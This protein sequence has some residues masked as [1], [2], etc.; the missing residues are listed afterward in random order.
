MTAQQIVDR[1]ILYEQSYVLNELIRVN[2]SLWDKIENTMV[3]VSLAEGGDFDSA[4]DVL[5]EQDVI[6]G[7]M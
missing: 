5:R 6:E 4:K 3:A 1:E 7:R 2:D